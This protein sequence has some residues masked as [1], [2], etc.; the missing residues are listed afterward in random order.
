[1][2]CAALAVFTGCEQPDDGSYTAPISLYEKING[3]WALADL[4][5][6]DEVAKANGVQP[7]DQNLSAFFNYEDFRL[8]LNV[9]ANNMPTTYE[10]GGDVPTLFEPQGYWMLANAFQQT[11]GK[12]A[13]ILLYA[14]A[15]HTQQTGEL[16]LT[17][18]PGSNGAMEL[19]L[20]RA[21]NGVAFVSYTFK[22][23]AID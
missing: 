17:A 20:V 19:Q 14:D 1:M 9:D 8:H 23:N 12:P 21:S 2:A 13:H 7:N 3:E 6:T 11:D 4:K 22:L 16:L 18:V 10:V 15:A 5:M